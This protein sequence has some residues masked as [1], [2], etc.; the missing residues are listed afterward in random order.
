MEYC[1][2][3][4]PRFADRTFCVQYLRPFIIVFPIK[5]SNNQMQGDFFGGNAAFASCFALVAHVGENSPPDCFLPLAP[6][7]FE[8]LRL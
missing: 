1:F 7:L 8:S 4:L 5:Y 2:A 6:S 3:I